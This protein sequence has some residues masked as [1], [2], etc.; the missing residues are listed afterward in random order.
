MLFD[1]EEMEHSKIKEQGGDF[2]VGPFQRWNGLWKW[3][4]EINR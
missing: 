4:V 1:G 3:I 2:Q